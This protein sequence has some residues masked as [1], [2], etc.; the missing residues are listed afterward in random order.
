MD[1]TPQRDASAGSPR[2]YVRLHGRIPVNGALA[3]RSGAPLPGYGERDL[4]LFLHPSLIHSFTLHR[5]IANCYVQTF[6]EALL[7]ELFQHLNPMTQQ[8]ALATEVSL[9]EELRKEG[10]GVWQN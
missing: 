6:G 4:L 9:A 5:S 7:P 3:P 2:A 1:A 8:R 10:F